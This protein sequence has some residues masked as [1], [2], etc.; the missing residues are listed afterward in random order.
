MAD[1]YVLAH[2]AQCKLKLAATRKDRDL[3]CLLGHAL[4]LDSL[5][6][7]IIDIENR[8]ASNPV[9]DATPA[10]LDMA[11]RGVKFQDN[12]A[13]SVSN[14]SPPG[15]RDSRKL[16]PPPGLVENIDSSSGE[17]EYEDNYDDEGDVD[18]GALTRFPSASAE[19]PRMIE[20][21]SDNED[22]GDELGSP[23]TL[24]ADFDV[25]AI[26]SQEPDEEMRTLYNSLQQCCC[27]GV[28][29]P[30]AGSVWNIPSKTG[31]GLRDLALVR[32][33]V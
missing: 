3:R 26:T 22:E 7:R 21:L 5:T 9:V 15:R 18:G 17:D 12:K 29:V 8:K 31:G 1:A 25:T 13:R 6:L 19:P 30:M 14:I 20:D 2:T 24:P 16:S 27:H 4:T 11:G 23:P 28:K 32:D 33:E 10:E